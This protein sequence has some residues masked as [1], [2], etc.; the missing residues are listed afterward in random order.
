MMCDDGDFNYDGTVN[1][2]NLTPFSHNLGQS[3]GSYGASEMGTLNSSLELSNGISL[4]NVPEPMS[5]G[6]VLMA[7]LGILGRRRPSC[8]ADSKQHL[9][10]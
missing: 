8:R 2:E 10:A 6:M 3:V 1:A 9:A 5:T 4:A 7:G